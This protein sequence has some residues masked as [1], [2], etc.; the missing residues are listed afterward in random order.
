MYRKIIDVVN[1]ENLFIQLPKEYL[2]K[3]VE[4]IAFEV[5]NTNEKVDKKKFNDAMAFF[6]TLNVDMSNFKFDRDE[7]NEREKNIDSSNAYYESEVFIQRMLEGQ[8]ELKQGKGIT[9][10][11]EEFEGYIHKLVG[12]K[13]L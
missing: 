3:Q 9:F 8:E 10:K 13:P 4:V 12:N 7:A 2:N 6:D 11:M 5:E 1:E